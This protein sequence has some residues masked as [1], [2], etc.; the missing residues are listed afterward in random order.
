MVSAGIDAGSETIKV[1]LFEGKLL[2]QAVLPI[3]TQAIRSLAKE[4]LRE[5]ARQAGLNGASLTRVAACGMGRQQVDFADESLGDSLCLAKA[6]AWLLPEAKTVL[7]IGAQK[8]L[9]VRSREGKPQ[10]FA[11][12]DKC[13]SGSGSYLEMVAKILEVGLE[14]MSRL[15]LC[16]S[17]AVPVNSTCAVF[18][19]S[20]IVSLIHQKKKPEDIAMGVCRGLAARVWPL[21]LQVAWQPEVL[22]VGGVARHKGIVAALEEPLGHRLVVP[23][24]PEMAMA[25]GAA[26]I[27]AEKAG[28]SQ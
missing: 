13:A 7:D 14:E 22:F 4:A 24:H 23:E 5:A 15:A 9:V 6:G 18:A 10:A 16:S 11:M 2:S 19:E 8:C 27:A 21:F 25:L 26:L 20:E 12:N 17:E 28:N 3:G 1:V